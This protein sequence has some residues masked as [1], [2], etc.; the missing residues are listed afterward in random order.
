M[1]SD[2]IITIMAI[3]SP[4]AIGCIMLVIHHNQRIQQS[5]TDSANIAIGIWTSWKQDLELRKGL[6]MLS[7]QDI[8]D[9]NNTSSISLALGEF[10]LIAILWRDRVLCEK[11]VL[12]FFSTYIVRISDNESVMKYLHEKNKNSSYIF[13]NL[14]KLVKYSKKWNIQLS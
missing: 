5:K 6:T 10:E 11:H 4:I 3:I 1:W 7:N 2:Y 14:I 8:V 9:V 13:A 12:E